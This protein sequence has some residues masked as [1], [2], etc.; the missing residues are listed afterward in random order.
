M[1]LQFN[2]VSDCAK[3][4]KLIT[5]VGFLFRLIE[6]CKS[7]L[8]E[9]TS[10]FIQ[11]SLSATFGFSV[12]LLH[13]AE[14]RGLHVLMVDLLGWAFE[15]E[16]TDDCTPVFQTSLTYRFQ[17]LKQEHHKSYLLQTFCIIPQRFK[18]HAHIRRAVRLNSFYFRPR[19]YQSV[20]IQYSVVNLSIQLMTILATSEGKISH[21]IYLPTLTILTWNTPLQVKVLHSKISAKCT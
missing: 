16:V 18:L 9:K 5:F 3:T 14:R 17:F 10:A 20:L 1:S 15:M 21:V 7:A 8:S 11:L 2:S 6:N 4:L 12:P 13:Q 19:C